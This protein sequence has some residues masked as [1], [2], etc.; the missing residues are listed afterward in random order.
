MAFEM[1]LALFSEKNACNGLERCA[2]LFF[3][4][5]TADISRNICP[6]HTLFMS[7][8]FYT[9]TIC[10]VM[11]PGNKNRG[12]D[13]IRVPRHGGIWRIVVGLPMVIA[14]GMVY[15]REFWEHTPRMLHP[16]GPPNSVRKNGSNLQSDSD[17]NG[18][19][20]IPYPAYFINL[21]RSTDR[22][23][24]FEYIF[25]DHVPA[26]RRISAVEAQNHTF[27][28]MYFP[29]DST[30][31]AEHVHVSSDIDI[32]LGKISETELGCILSHLEAIRTAYNDGCHAALIMED[33][34]SS[35]LTPFW[36]YTPADA[37]RETE[38][39]NPHWTV[40]QVETLF[41]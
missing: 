39:T 40:I 37:I 38:A 28:S 17:D 35:L 15:Q 4:V 34:T 10:Q 31:Y 14:F 18:S 27:R 7:H 24:V 32:P 8:T 26:L 13:W 9:C 6:A 11:T 41:K 2:F 22:R 29:N 1:C 21:D 19:W 5:Q 36:T 23:R 20:F 25:N 12:P 30:F 33:D 16:E 3:V